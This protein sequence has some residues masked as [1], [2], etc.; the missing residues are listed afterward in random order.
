[1]WGVTP[2][3]RWDWARLRA[4]I[5]R[6]GVRNSLLTAIMPTASTSIIL[7]N[8]EATE[9]ISSVMENRRVLAG[10]FLVVSKQLVYDLVKRGLWSEH[11]RQQIIAAFG[12][13]QH[14]DTIPD[15]LKAL[16]RTVWDMSQRSL[17]EMAVARAPY[18]CQSQSLNLYMANPNT[19][20]LS[21]MHMFAWERG[22]KTG[23]YYLRSQ[24]KMRANPTTVSREL[25]VLAEQAMSGGGGPSPAAA[26]GGDVNNK[27]C[28]EE[29]CVMCSA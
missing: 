1:L 18:I 29:V 15:D 10:E 4:R 21:S 6:Y 9:A 8:T 12:S 19:A 20:K 22:L 24:A 11:M 16:Y 28:T 14:I 23:C 7:G 17:I 3:A 2:S 5:A 25:Q 27:E 13:V 26:G